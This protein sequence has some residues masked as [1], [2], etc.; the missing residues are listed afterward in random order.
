MGFHDGARGCFW[1]LVGGGQGTSYN[2]QDSPITAPS[3]ILHTQVP[4]VP[5]LR[6]PE[7]ATNGASV[8]VRQN[9]T[10]S[11]YVVS[12]LTLFCK[13]LHLSSGDDDAFIASLAA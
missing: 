9:R 10:E 4:F 1:H 6:T 3:K 5:R 8:G 7:L 11:R 13:C 12:S 2:A